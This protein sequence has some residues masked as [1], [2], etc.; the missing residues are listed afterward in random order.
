ME[1]S[2]LCCNFFPFFT[3]SRF[4]FNQISLK[5]QNVKIKDREEPSELSDA[6]YKQMASVT[7][8]V[9]QLVVEFAKHLP[10]FMTLNRDDQIVLLKVS[11]NMPMV[12]I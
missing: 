2:I 12:Y 1:Q 3:S 8:M 10:G 9:T 11:N 6:I 7:I 4:K 5:F